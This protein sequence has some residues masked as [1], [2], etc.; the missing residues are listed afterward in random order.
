[1]KA[2]NDEHLLMTFS[3]I[4]VLEDDTRQP[5]ELDITVGMV[6]RYLADPHPCQCED[7]Q[8]IFPPAARLLGLQEDLLAAR[9]T[10]R[11]FKRE[12]KQ[13]GYV[14]EGKILHH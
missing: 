1:M 3:G 7:C 14:R 4:A 8:R 5:I 13:M 10:K 6:R 2:L 9:I 12:L 11:Q